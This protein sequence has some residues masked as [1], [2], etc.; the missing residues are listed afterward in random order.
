MEKEILKEIR[1]KN[2]SEFADFL[3]KYLTEKDYN[4]RGE[5]QLTEKGYKTLMKNFEQRTLASIEKD[6]NK[7]LVG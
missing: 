4:K 3:D 2:D 7:M 5:I 6:Y 1:D